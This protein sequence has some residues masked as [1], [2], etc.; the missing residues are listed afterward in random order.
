MGIVNAWM[1]G[2]SLPLGWKIGWP[3]GMAPR[4]GDGVVINRVRL[5]RLPGMRGAR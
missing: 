4:L 5:E 3:N 1:S 2:T